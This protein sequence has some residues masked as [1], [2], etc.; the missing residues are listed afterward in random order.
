MFMAHDD[1]DGNDGFENDFDRRELLVMFEEVES[2]ITENEVLKS[3]KQHD[4]INY[5]KNNK[6]TFYC[7]F[8]D[9]RKAFDYVDHKNLWYKLVCIGIHG[10]MLSIV[11]SMYPSVTSSVMGQT[12]LTYE[13]DCTL[14]VRQGEGLVN[15]YLLCT[16]MIWKIHCMPME[17]QVLLLIP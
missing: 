1:D 15:L 14:G 13:F 10:K 8:I 9:Y 3:V 16:L 17:L 12:G 4:L 7:A 5:C 2:P 6:K 11:K